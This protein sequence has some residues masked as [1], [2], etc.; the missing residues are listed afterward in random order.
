[1]MLVLIQLRCDKNLE[2]YLFGVLICFC[3]GLEF[4]F[5]IIEFIAECFIVFFFW[6]SEDESLEL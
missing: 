1:M 6:F 4:G 5:N 3:F 2:F